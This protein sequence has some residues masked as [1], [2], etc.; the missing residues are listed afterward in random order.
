MRNC[1]SYLFV[2]LIVLLVAA[3]SRA[4]QPVAA[5]TVIVYNKAADDSA[6]LARFYAKQRGIASDHI[7]GLNCSNSEEISREEYD[8]SIADPLREAFKEHGWWMLRETA[9]HETAVM[10]TSIRFVALMKG[11]PLKVK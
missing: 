4:E 7:V 5:S 10:A 6:E 1:R 2:L 3:N 8:A 11:M 9:D